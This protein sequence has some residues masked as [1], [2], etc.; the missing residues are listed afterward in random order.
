LILGWIP[1]LRIIFSIW[2]LIL[3]TI[4]IRELHEISTGK[5][6]TAVLITIITPVVIAIVIAATIYIYISVMLSG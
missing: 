2:T 5:A 3:F 1:I 6:V 4:G